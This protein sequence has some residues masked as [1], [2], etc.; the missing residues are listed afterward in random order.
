VSSSKT[1]QYARKADRWSD[2]E[3]ADAH[4]YLDH[5]AEL[6]TTLGRLLVAGEEVLDIACGDAGLGEHLLARGLRYRGVDSE[7]SMVAAAARRLGPAVPVELGEL[8]TYEPPAPVA[9]TTV[10][11]AIYYVRDRPAFFARVASYTERKLVFDLNPR[12]YRVTEIVDELGA[13]GF[14]HVAMRPFF[15]PQTKGL[16][17]PFVAGLKGLERSGPLARLALR[18]RFTYVI[19]ALC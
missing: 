7:P 9:A 5:R 6:V 1:D 15:V 4:A 17:A 12:Q 10:F 18:Y 3:Y 2:T 19:A 11:R 8:D 16:P 13:A 14:P